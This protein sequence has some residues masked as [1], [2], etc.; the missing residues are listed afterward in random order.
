MLSTGLFYL[1]YSE[2]RSECGS[3]VGQLQDMGEIPPEPWNRC[4]AGAVDR[5][6]RQVAAVVFFKPFGVWEGI[7][8]R[9]RCRALSMQAARQSAEVRAG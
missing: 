7:E 9:A 1:R 2:S 8:S 6:L 4:L 5:V 3:A